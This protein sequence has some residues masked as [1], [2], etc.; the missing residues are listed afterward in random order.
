MKLEATHDELIT[1][2]GLLSGDPLARTTGLMF[3]PEN[4]PK[5]RHY[6][7]TKADLEARARNG[8]V[9]DSPHVHPFF[10]LFDVHELTGLDD[11][12]QIEVGPNQAV[13][14]AHGDDELIAYA[15]GPI[16]PEAR[17]GV[18]GRHFLLTMKGKAIDC[19][20]GQD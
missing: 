6:R 11:M 14:I 12:T 2:G 19:Q 9:V 4:L 20:N 3:G 8:G 1:L 16:S 15:Y 18:I 10:E 7:E 17:S 13:V 5:R